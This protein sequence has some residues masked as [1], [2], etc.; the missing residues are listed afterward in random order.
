MMYQVVEVT[1]RR[2]SNGEFT[3]D[4]MTLCSFRDKS[5]CE[6]YIKNLYFSMMGLG[7]EKPSLT[8]NVYKKTYSIEQ[9]SF[10]GYT[11]KIKVDEVVKYLVTETWGGPDE[12]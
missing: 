1:Q 8:G 2:T 9:T 7:Y 5:E 12:Q 11:D 10:M 6:Q 3:Q 4:K